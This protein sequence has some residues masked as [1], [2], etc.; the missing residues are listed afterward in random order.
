M[1]LLDK[2]IGQGNTVP[3]LPGC[4]GLCHVVTGAD[5]QT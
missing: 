4:A 2:E 5:Q 3:R 1:I